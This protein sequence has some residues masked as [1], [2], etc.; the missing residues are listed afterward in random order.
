MGKIHPYSRETAYGKIGTPPLLYS[1]ML[2]KEG[3]AVKWDAVIVSLD[4]TA[5]FTKN[6]ILTLVVNLIFLKEDVNLI[7]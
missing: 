2:T 5:S 1:R 4:D 7:S 6:T 3:D